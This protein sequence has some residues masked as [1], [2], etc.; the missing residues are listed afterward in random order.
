MHV[1]WY[2]YIQTASSRED[3]QSWVALFVSFIKN[4]PQGK[5]NIFNMLQNIYV[6]NTRCLPVLQRSRILTDRWNM[7]SHL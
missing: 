5:V 7:N 1:H 6:T 3:A 2:S 4:I